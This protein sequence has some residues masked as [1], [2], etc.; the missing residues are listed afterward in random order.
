MTKYIP[1]GALFARQ[2]PSLLDELRHLSQNAQTLEA[3]EAA[4][5]CQYGLVAF[6]A[7]QQ[8]QEDANE[9][10][11][12]ANDLAQKQVRAASHLREKFS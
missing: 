7:G 3:R 5:V 6:L 8:Q 9:Q 4:S 11:Q 2:E 12:D 10:R 1:W